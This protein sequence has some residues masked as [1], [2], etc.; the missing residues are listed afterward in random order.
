[1]SNLLEYIVDFN[2]KAVEQSFKML[3][4]T[5]KQTGKMLEAFFDYAPQIPE[6]SKNVFRNFYRNSTE[7][8]ESIKKSVEA[9]LNV[10]VNETE[11]PVQMLKV[12]EESVQDAFVLA[13]KIQEQNQELV[14]QLT[15]DLPKEGKQII[16]FLSETL[17]NNIEAF[18]DIIN[19]NFAL[20]N[21]IIEENQ[22]T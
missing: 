12:F 21:K 9:T 15:A 4:Q 3:D 16:E 8:L 10:D 6:D 20:A 14:S 17:N 13:S 19:K 2:K 1:M 22:K 5:S 7:G 11:A 18:K